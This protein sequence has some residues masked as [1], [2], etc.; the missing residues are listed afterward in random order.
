M[1][2]VLNWDVRSF[3]SYRNEVKRSKSEVGTGIGVGAEDE[4]AVG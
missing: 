4:E 3:G 2:C 1:T